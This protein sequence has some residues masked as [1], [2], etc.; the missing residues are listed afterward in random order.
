MQEHYEIVKVLG[1]DKSTYNKYEN[2]K[3]R[4]NND[5]VEELA[6]YYKVQVSGYKLNWS[7]ATDQFVE[8]NKYVRKQ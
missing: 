3:R 2:G 6:D 5:V 4:L 7:V 8:R 1:V